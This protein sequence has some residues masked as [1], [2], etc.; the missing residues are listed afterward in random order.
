MPAQVAVDVGVVP[1]SSLPCVVLL[2]FPRRAAA[3]FS[4]WIPVRR[5]KFFE[6]R[7]A[8]FVDDAA[9]V[10]LLGDDGALRYEIHRIWG[11][12]PPARLPAQEYLVQWRGYDTAQMTWVRR[13]TLLQDVPDLLRAYEASPTTAQARKS[14]PRRASAAPVRR[15]ARHRPS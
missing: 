5:L 9:P 12:R 11:H 14:A 3:E 7:D 10:P 8:A 4:P 1:R 2:R 15:S 6:Q 13:A